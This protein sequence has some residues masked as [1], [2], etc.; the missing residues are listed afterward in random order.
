MRR[1]AE[2]APPTGPHAQSPKAAIRRA[3]VADI[4]ALVALENRTFSGDWLSPRSFRHLILY[5]HAAT[6]VEEWQ[7]EVRGYA[8]VFF[9]QLSP[10]ARLYSFAIAPEHR[11]QGL[12]AALLAAAERA[13]RE[14]GC[15]TM[16]LEVRK[17]N[18]RA[19]AIYRKAGYRTFGS[20]TAYYD[21]GTDAVRME[22]RLDREGT[23]T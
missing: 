7:G 9:R 14:H 12:A 2:R 3:T 6:L 4:P 10:T 21:D 1:G 19:Q 15:S 18:P 23:G 11:G 5:G 16:R 22:K 17:D 20:H 13:A 8:V